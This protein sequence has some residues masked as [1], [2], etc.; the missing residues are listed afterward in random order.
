MPLKMQ[1]PKRAYFQMIFR[2]QERS[3]TSVLQAKGRGKGLKSRLFGNYC[4]DE[5]CYSILLF[6]LTKN[7][8]KIYR[9]RY[10]VLKRRNFEWIFEKAIAGV[11]TYVK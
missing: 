5:V 1:A 11:Y 8:C 6:A 9:L 2:E 7:D 3:C 4:I 10:K